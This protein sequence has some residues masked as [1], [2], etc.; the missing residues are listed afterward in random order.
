[1]NFKLALTALI[2]VL[3]MELVVLQKL[4]NRSKY[5]ESEFV[6]NLANSTPNA[7]GGGG[8]GRAM[9]IDTFAPLAG[10]GVAM[11]LFKIDPCGINLPHVHPRGTELFYVVKGTFK[12]AFTEENSGR[13]IVNTLTPGQATI[14]PQGLIHEEQNIGC[15][16][17]IFISAFSDED[18]GVLTISNRMFTLPD[19]ALQATFAENKATINKLKNGLPVNPA[20]GHNECLKKCG[21]KNNNNK[22]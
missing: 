16:E 9:N 21:I 11:V 22:Q 17:A 13:T 2:L 10:E 14:F 3:S 20:K 19:E 8:N 6:F 4:K 5:Q 1:M 12:T 18:P 15:E 7:I